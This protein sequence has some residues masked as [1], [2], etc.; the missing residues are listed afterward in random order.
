MSSTPSA[1]LFLCI[2]YL[3][4]V[5]NLVLFADRISASDI[6]DFVKALPR[7]PSSYRKKEEPFSSREVELL[8]LL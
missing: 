4:D 6:V 7:T 3:S 2:F 5:Q 1:F 8:L